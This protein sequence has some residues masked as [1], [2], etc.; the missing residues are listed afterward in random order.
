MRR[1]RSYGNP[2]LHPNQVRA[3]RS[4][5]IEILT[6]EQSAEHL[7][8]FVTEGGEPLPAIDGLAFR[9]W[10]LVRDEIAEM[11]KH[12]RKLGHGSTEPQPLRVFA[13]DPK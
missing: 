7:D 13:G 6:E 8:A 9:L 1:V 4:L 3:L 11:A 12:R 5:I 10:H 2:E